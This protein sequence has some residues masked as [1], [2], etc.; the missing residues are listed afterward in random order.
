MIESH[1]AK[2]DLLNKGETLTVMIP[3]ALSLLFKLSRS[4]T[5]CTFGIALAPGDLCDWVSSDRMR[6]A[7]NAQTLWQ[8]QLS[9]LEGHM[10]ACKCDEL[11]TIGTDRPAC[12]WVVGSE[13]E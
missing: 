11:Q 1:C 3:S 12:K 2:L 5:V 9:S 13:V 6:E 8:Y 7:V 10:N 4:L